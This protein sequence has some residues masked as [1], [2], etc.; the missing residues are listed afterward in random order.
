M[1]DD[2]Q[3]ITTTSFYGRKIFSTLQEAADAIESHEDEA[4]VI[5]LPPEPDVLTDQ[6]E[7]DDDNIMESHI[8]NDVPGY[9]EVNFGN[10][11]EWS[12]S[13]DEPLSI[14]VSKRPRAEERNPVWEK[15][16]PV[17]VFSRDTENG[18]NDRLEKVKESL[19][20]YNPVQIFEKLFDDNVFQLM[21]E[22]SIIYSR[23]K[24]NHDFFATM[25]EM[26]I[27]IGILLL[28]GY[29]KLPQQ[30]M[31]WSLDEDLGVKI[32]SGSISRNRF[33]EIKRYL[34]FADNDKINKN[35]KMFK[36]RPLMDILNKNFRQWGFFHKSLSVDEAMVKYFGHH[37]AKQFI[38][39][40][41]VRFGFKDWMLCSST[42]YCYAFDTYCGKNSEK[43]GQSLGL[44]ADVV[45]SLLEHLDNPADHIVY[46]DNFFTTLRL[47]N[48]LTAKGIRATGTIRENRQKN[49]NI[50]SSKMMD[51]EE[52]GTY[53]YRFNCENN[54]LIVKWK[55]NS[56]CSMASN[57][58]FIEPLNYVKRWSRAKKE[59]T[60]VQQPLVFQNYNAGMGGVDLNDQA[61]NTYRIS[62]RGK[63]WWWCLFTHMV[64]VTMTNS[65]KLHQI[66]ASPE[67]KI[68][69]LDFT[70]YVARYYLRLN[71]K[72]RKTNRPC[73]VPGAVRYDN[74]GHFPEKIEKQLRCSVCHLRI[75]WR[76]KKCIVTLCVERECF[77]K[78]H[79]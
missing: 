3:P 26:K 34:H 2:F 15:I 29:H 65:W 60:T 51:K 49:C 64:N 12:D 75:R 5:V 79:T 40:K 1:D 8:P 28:S 16:E 11:D 57:H 46:F 31:Y 72:T 30:R 7:F 77:E 66:C 63:K 47:M 33:L 17:Y 24:N 54:L 37:S 67:E 74:V 43:K 36:L 21:I 14:F 22:Q 61:T 41:P 71:N 38:R 55:D 18:A 42:G 58:D 13:D 27:F 69:L 35:D 6:E 23:Q 9:I 53:D 78:Y 50:Q 20:G 19:R 59:I 39:G 62:I 4:D 76:C 70:R 32:V 25:E 52:R 73:Q 44:G 68:S 56:V 45:I 48:Q 10:T